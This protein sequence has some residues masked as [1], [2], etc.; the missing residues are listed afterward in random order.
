MVGLPCRNPRIIW[1]RQVIY[2]ALV[3]GIPPL[4]GFNF[5]SFYEVPEI[6]FGYASLTHRKEVLKNRKVYKSEAITICEE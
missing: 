6:F 2:K 5:F 4:P 1:K 3:G